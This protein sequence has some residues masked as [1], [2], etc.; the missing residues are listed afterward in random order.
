[1][2]ADLVPSSKLVCR[3]TYD[4]TSMSWVGFFQT[5]GWA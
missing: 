5:S 1:M 2:A 3:M 4:D